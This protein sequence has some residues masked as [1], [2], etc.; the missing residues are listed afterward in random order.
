[1]E[2]CYDPD[3]VDRETGKQVHRHTG[4]QVG[5]HTSCELVYLCTY[6]PIYLFPSFARKQTIVSRMQ[7]FDPA[8]RLW[9]LLWPYIHHLRLINRG[10]ELISSH[11]C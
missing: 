6:L 4:I 3:L 7:P 8:H 1:M 11:H 10:R 2:E 5:E 9:R